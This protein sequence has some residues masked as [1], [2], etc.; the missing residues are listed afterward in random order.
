MVPRRIVAAF[1]RVREKV[2]SMGKIEDA[3]ATMIANMPEKTGKSLDQW[4]KVV[5]KKKL[6]QHGEIVSMLKADHGIGHGFANLIAHKSLASDAGSHDGDD[7]LAAQY[8]GQK[9][10]LRP[11]YDKLAK[12]IEGFGNDVEFAPKK[13]Y[14]S[15]RRSK[16]FGLIQPSTATRLD[17]GLN[18]KSVAPSSRLEAAGSWNAMCS[19]RVK[20]TSATDVDAEV[21]AWLKQAYDAA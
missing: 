8:A 6:Q 14:M 13:A 5:A 12:I 15:L 4:L 9:A 3:T 7:L 10:A 16:Q 19:H 11:I 1:Q 17:L 20:L 21:K 18:L 2:I